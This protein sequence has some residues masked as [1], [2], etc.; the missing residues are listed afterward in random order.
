MLEV[1]QK[2]DGRENDDPD[3]IDEVPIKADR[4]D[5]AGVL[6]AELDG[7]RAAAEPNDGR[8]GGGT[9]DQRN[10]G[11]VEEFADRRAVDDLD[12]TG[13][14]PDE[15]NTHQYRHGREV[16]EVLEEPVAVR[17]LEG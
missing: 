16:D 6:L 5:V 17:R 8:Q 4:L 3:D 7:A 12:A 11:V 13:D 1:L 14:D 10:R 9:H 2:V 15:G